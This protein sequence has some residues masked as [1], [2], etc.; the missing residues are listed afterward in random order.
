MIL[1]C[2]AL[3]E[4]ALLTACEGSKIWTSLSSGGRMNMRGRT[5]VDVLVGKMNGDWKLEI[6]GRSCYG[7]MVQYNIQALRA[8]SASKTK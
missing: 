8:N 1:R 4:R 6:M 3:L 5:E 2:A 7:K